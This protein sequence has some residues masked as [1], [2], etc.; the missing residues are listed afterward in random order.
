MAEGAVE[1]ARPHGWRAALEWV[2]DRWDALRDIGRVGRHAPTAADRAEAER[3]FPAALEALE[4][5]HPREAMRTLREVVRLDGTFLPAHL[6]LGQAYLRQGTPDRALRAW[7]DG[8][9]ATRARPLLEAA[10]QLILEQERPERML[11]FYQQALRRA[12]GDLLLRYALGRLYFRLDMLEPAGV[13][14]EA[15]LA[16]A[17]AF[18]PAHLTLGQICERRGQPEEAARRFRAG[19]V[20]AVEATPEFRCAT[21]RAPA[22][23]WA[24]RCPAC[25]RWNRLEDL[26]AQAL[27]PGAGLA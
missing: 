8:Y 19:L 1:A 15:L 25:G 16:Q 4:A 18:L 20:T 22:S 12:P 11:D 14:F 3:R 2:R 17:P 5:G 7:V 9:E 27:R 24:D 13:E 10:E 21:C 23:A 26:R 6:R